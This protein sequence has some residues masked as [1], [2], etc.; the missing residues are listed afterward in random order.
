MKKPQTP[1]KRSRVVAWYSDGGLVG[2][3]HLLVGFFNRSISRIKFGHLAALPLPRNR[4][5]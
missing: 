4:A 5:V 2:L 1:A 3:P